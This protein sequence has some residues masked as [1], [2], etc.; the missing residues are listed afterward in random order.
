MKMNDLI[1]PLNRI[2]IADMIATAFPPSRPAR[3]QA[4]RVGVEKALETASAGLRL[5]DLYETGT[6]AFDAFHAGVAEGRAIWAR[7]IAA[8]AALPRRLLA[9]ANASDLLAAELIQAGQIITVMLNHMTAVQ[10]GDVRLQLEKQGVVT[11][12]GYASRAPER[13]AALVAAGFAEA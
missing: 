7:H 12:A 3:S 4:Y 13:Q 1:Q 6:V 8:K 10:L 9:P 5:N 11:S 2:E